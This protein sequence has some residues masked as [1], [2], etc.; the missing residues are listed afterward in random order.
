ML[1]LRNFGGLE[2]YVVLVQPD[3]IMQMLSDTKQEIISAFT[4][5]DTDWYRTATHDL[6]LQA[7]AFHCQTGELKEGSWS[8]G[9][10][11]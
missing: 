1:I 6:K 2:K 10:M 8:L 7:C 5:L 9:H 4:M 3:T 11:S